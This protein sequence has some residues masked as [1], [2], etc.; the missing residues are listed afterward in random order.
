MNI[1][2][3]RNGFRASYNQ[4]IPYYSLILLLVLALLYPGLHWTILIS[5]TFLIISITIYIFYRVLVE[6]I[7][8][9][10]ETSDFFIPLESLEDDQK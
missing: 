6:S 7:S 9:Q 8:I 10:D 2:R 5:L 1:T 3:L 4:L